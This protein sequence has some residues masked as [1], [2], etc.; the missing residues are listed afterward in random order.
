MIVCD[1]SCTDLHFTRSNLSDQID[2]HKPRQA[3]AVMS[4]QREE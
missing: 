4:V 3:D 1:V 2:S